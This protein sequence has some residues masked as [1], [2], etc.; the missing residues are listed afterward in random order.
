MAQG[1]GIVKLVHPALQT[2]RGMC[3]DEAPYGDIDLALA[4]TIET[5]KGLEGRVAELEAAM[6]AEAYI[7]EVQALGQGRRRILEMQVRITDQQR[8][9]LSELVRLGPLTPSHFAGQVKPISAGT[10]YP[11]IT[12]NSASAVLRRMGDRGLVEKHWAHDP[13]RITDDGRR[14]LGL[15]SMR[16][17]P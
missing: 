9:F 4:L 8:W 3:T 1:R 11:K 13:W 14:A 12:R 16:D 10:W 7:V 17:T 6:A 5:V 2:V 15:W